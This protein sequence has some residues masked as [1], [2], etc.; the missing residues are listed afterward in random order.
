MPKTRRLPK[1]H[2]PDDSDFTKEPVDIY[3]PWCKQCTLCVSLCPKG[4]F[5]IL[6]TGEIQAVH[7]DECIQC[8]MCV[9]HCPDFAILLRERRKKKP[10]PDN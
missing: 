10:R 5:E 6:E 3:Q 9:L 2:M 1:Y 8:Q 4:V 7:N